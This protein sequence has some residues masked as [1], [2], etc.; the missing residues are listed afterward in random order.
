MT[1]QVKRRVF[2]YGVAIDLVILVTG[3][4]LLLD[5]GAVFLTVAFL[6]AVALSSWKGGWPGGIAAVVASLLAM[7]AFFG[8]VTTTSYMVAFAVLGTVITGAVRSLVPMNVA[9]PA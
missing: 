2:Q 9:A 4:G 1:P 7:L 6:T 5:S 3:L 8:D